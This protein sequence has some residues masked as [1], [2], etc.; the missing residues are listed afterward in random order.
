M[1]MKRLG[2]S[3]FVIIM[4]SG[5]ASAWGQSVKQIH[6]SAPPPKWDLTSV[7]LKA[8]DSVEWIIS[9]GSHGVMILGWD[10]AQQ[11]LEPKVAPQTPKFALPAQG[12]TPNAMLRLRVKAAPDQR[13]EIPFT[14]TVH[15]PD[16]MQGKLI[17]KK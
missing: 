5:A 9:S 15:G 14:C 10:K 13:T 4:A 1:N 8:G 17:L 2:L 16:L 7:E 3:L 11:F 12:T 6:G